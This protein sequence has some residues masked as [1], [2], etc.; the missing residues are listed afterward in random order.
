MTF[1]M[2]PYVHRPGPLGPCGPDWPT[3]CFLIFM[4][5]VLIGGMLTV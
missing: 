2:P 4:L 5:G 3:I 1:I